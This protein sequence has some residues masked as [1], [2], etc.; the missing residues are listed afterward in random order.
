MNRA[1]NLECRKLF[2]ELG[3]IGGHGKFQDP[4]N[5]PITT[6]PA[7]ESMNTPIQV[8]DLDDIIELHDKFT[9]RI[10]QLCLLDPKSEQLLKY[11][12][13]IVDICQEFRKLVKSYL[14]SD[15][16]DLISDDADSYYDRT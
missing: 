15:D 10:L 11:I 7:S 14:L 16:I 8:K 4:F 12:F 2:Q 1:T 9:G 3:K 6:G 5:L 13:D